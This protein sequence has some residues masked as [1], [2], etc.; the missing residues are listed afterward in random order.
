MCYIIKARSI[1]GFV[2]VLK[3]YAHCLI[4][5]GEVRNYSQFQTLSRKIFIMIFIMICLITYKENPE[6]LYN[7]WLNR[8]NYFL[9]D[10]RFINT[11]DLDDKPFIKL[12]PMCYYYR[13]G[14][15]FVIWYINNIILRH[16]KVELGLFLYEIL[17][18]K[19]S[20]IL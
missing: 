14:I 17:Y 7:F 2:I 4:T 12:L 18:K 11:L 5:F 8:N 1:N 10:I 16:I 13:L 3:K 6:I 19:H 20:Y 9:S 15:L